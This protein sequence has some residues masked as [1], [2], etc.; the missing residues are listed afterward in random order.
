MIAR[1]KSVAGAADLVNNSEWSLAIVDHD[2]PDGLGTDALDALRA[3]YPALPIVMLTRQGG[4]EMAV[5]AFRHG[6]SDY[7]V[8]ADGYAGALAA[9]VTGLLAD[10]ETSNPANPNQSL[11]RPSAPRVEVNP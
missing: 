1:V 8:K 10:T 11:R 5:D 9:R 2:L 4:D 3:A 6:A 7:V